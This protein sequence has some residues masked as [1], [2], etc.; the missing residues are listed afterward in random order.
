MYNICSIW[1][2]DIRFKVMHK[3]IVISRGETYLH[4]GR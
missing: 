1:F 3:F 2:L 4:V